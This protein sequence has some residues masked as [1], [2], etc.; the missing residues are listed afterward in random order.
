MEELSSDRLTREEEGSKSLRGDFWPKTN[1]GTGY[2]VNVGSSEP[3]ME[4]NA[5]NAEM[6]DLENEVIEEMVDQAR[7]FVGSRQERE[8]AHWTPL[9]DIQV[10]HLICFHSSRRFM[11]GEKW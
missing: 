5:H 3:C 2:K 9:G 8:L 1:H 7:H 4:P 6:R 11:G 10:G